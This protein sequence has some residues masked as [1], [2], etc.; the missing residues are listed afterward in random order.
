MRPDYGWETERR[1]LGRAFWVSS[2]GTT[3]V[4]NNRILKTTGVITANCVTKNKVLKTS[5]IVT[6]CYKVTKNCLLYAWSYER[7]SYHLIYLPPQ[8]TGVTLK[9]HFSLSN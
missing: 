7:N 8:H 2:F 6:V 3:Y 4:A 5:P 9:T 1:K